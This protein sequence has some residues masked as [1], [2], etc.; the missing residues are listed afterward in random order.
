MRA[1]FI[2]RLSGPDGLELR[3]APDPE[4]GPGQ[5]RLR[6][7]AAGI[8][9]ADHLMTLGLYVGAPKPPYVPGYE[10][11]GEIDR[12][13]AGV[14]GLKPGARVL[15]AMKAGGYAERVVAA[16]NSVIPIPDGKSFEEAAAIPVNYM[17]AY[18]ALYVLGNLR[19]RCRVLVHGA[20][21]GVGI[22]AIQLAKL[23]DATIIGTASA[24]KHAFAREQGAHHMIDYRTEDFEERVRELTG[25]KGVHL[26]LDP[27]GGSSFRKSYACLAET[28]LLV[29]YGASA[30]ASWGGKARALMTLLASGLFS[31]LQLMLQNRGV[32]GFH[33][34]RLES[35]PE[36][37]FSEMGELMR[38]WREGKI[39]PHV[40]AAIPAE[41]AAEAHRRLQRRQN[42]GKVVLTF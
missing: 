20:G 19:P 27:V 12:V 3:Q 8:N 6:V 10:A 13:G 23:R 42:I 41:R 18:H 11:A 30:M 36:L 40:D 2:A 29:A 34:G 15:T 33:L 5:V 9:F 16:A 32:V 17:T 38:L 14:T 39:Q 31:P 1:V 7:R 28:G 21:G 35:E 37:F 26:A 24:A 22:A 25:G 4:P